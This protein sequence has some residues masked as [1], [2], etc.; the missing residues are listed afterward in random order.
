MPIYKEINRNFFKKW[1][2]AMAYVLGFLYADGNIIYTKR[3]TWFWSLQ[4]TDKDI[5]E[6]IKKALNSSHVISKKKKHI[7]QKQS[8]RLQVGSREMCEDSIQLGLTERKSKTILLPKIQ[9]KYFPDFLRGYFDGDGG[10]WVGFTNKQRKHKT[11]AISTV[12]TSGSEQFLLS[13]KDLLKNYGLMSGSLVHKERGY[14]LKYS[15]RDSF[16]LYK[17]MYNSNCS[18]FLKRKKE[19]FESYMRMRS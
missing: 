16:I 19:K 8:Y 11:Y 10:V 5:L 14:D 9:K 3:R 12:L 13:L 15:I 18:L 6:D 17:I 7:N 2:N 4:I 1:T